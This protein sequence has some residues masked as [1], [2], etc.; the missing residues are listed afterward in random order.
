MPAGTEVL[1]PSQSS[2]APLAGTAQP[3]QAQC[4]A[5]P[6]RPG[7]RPRFRAALRARPSM[8]PQ[9]AHLNTRSESSMRGLAL[10][11]QLLSARRSEPWASGQRPSSQRSTSRAAI[12]PLPAAVTAWRYRRSERSPAANTPSTLVAV[13]PPWVRT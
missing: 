1:L 9:A 8:S 12:H 4:S 10:A 6:A 11:P 3:G 5:Q 13:V 7:A 2:G